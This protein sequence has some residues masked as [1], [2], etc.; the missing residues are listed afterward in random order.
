MPKGT[1]GCSGEFANFRLVHVRCLTSIQGAR[2]YGSADEIFLDAHRVRQPSGAVEF[3]DAL[4]DALREGGAPMSHASAKV[5]TKVTKI[6]NK[7]DSGP[8]THPNVS[9]KVVPSSLC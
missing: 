2:E 7:L 5:G 1:R 6:R 9:F 3:D 8:D 4:L